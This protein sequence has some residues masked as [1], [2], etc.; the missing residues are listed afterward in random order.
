[1]VGSFAGIAIIVIEYMFSILQILSMS[2]FETLE[3]SAFYT[4][5]YFIFLF[6]IIGVFL[7]WI[8]GLCDDACSLV[9]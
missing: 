6:D 2:L 5:T 1:M 9:L 8:G 3:A 7:L 4:Y